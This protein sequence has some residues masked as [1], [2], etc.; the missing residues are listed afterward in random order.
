MLWRPAPATGPALAVW[1]IAN[2]HVIEARDPFALRVLAWSVFRG[3]RG[4]CAGVDQVKAW[5]AMCGV[6][7]VRGGEARGARGGVVSSVQGA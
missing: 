6:R 7:Y 1:V 2:R 5:R 3:M 4:G